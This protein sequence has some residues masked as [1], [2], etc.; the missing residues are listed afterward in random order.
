MNSFLLASI[1]AVSLP[2]APAVLA[3]PQQEETQDRVSR[4]QTE[5]LRRANRLWNLMQD[6]LVRYQQEEGRAQQI[7]LLQKGIAHLEESGL[8]E[9]VADIRIDLQAAAFNEALRKQEEVIKELENLLDI[10][11][12]RRSV[13]NLDKEI[14]EAERMAAEARALEERQAQIQQLTREAVRSD[15]TPAEREL[16]ESLR[17]LAQ[18]EAEEARANQLDSGLRRPEL[19]YALRRIRDLL[20]QQTRLEETARRELA[21]ERNPMRDEIFRLGERQEETQSLMRQRSTQQQMA[22]LEQYAD[23]LRQAAQNRDQVQEVIGFHRSKFC[24]NEREKNVPEHAPEQGCT[25]AFFQPYLGE[26][27]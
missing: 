7:E 16:L 20:E 10:L 3:S 13:E 15:P 17:Q 12:D 1:L 9:G 4:D 19:E 18:R 8:L 11:L 6:L 2:T 25:P 5:V 26:C 21:G 24:F 27:C 22:R 14:A 23:R